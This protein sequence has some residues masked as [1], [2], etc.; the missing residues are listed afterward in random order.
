MPLTGPAGPTSD[1]TDLH[2]WAEAYLPGAGWIGMDATSGLFAGEGHIPLACTPEPMSAAPISG[3][4]MAPA[5]AEFDVAMSVTRLV[6]TPRV[7]KP[8]TDKQ[9]QDILVAGDRVDAALLGGDVRLT[10][11]GE[12]TF[13]SDKDPEGKEWTIDALGPTKRREAG[14]ADPP[15]DRVVGAGRDA[16]I[17]RGQALSG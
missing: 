11:G 12:P 8:Y 10:M 5:E 16:A 4:L 13:V 14:G 9:W 2:A 17:R 15:A 6:E 7:T 3:A 1:F